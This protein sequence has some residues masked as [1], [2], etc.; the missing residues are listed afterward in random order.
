MNGAPG[1]LAAHLIERADDATDGE[2]VD[3][4]PRCPGAAQQLCHLGAGLRVRRDQSIQWLAQG[5]VANPLMLAGI[6]NGAVWPV[7]PELSVVVQECDIERRLQTQ[8]A[9][10]VR[11]ARH[12][13]RRAHA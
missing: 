4:V 11:A 8:A 3:R 5:V 10:S 2:R 7:A 13:N 1:L 6:A 9:R 12:I